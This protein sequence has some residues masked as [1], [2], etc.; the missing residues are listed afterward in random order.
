MHAD[1]SAAVLFFNIRNLETL[2]IW[3]NGS[4]SD[5]R[6]EGW[7]FV[8]LCG[9]LFKIEPDDMHDKQFVDLEQEVLNLIV[10]TGAMAQR[11]RV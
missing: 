2:A 6:S 10:I 9:H 3:R 4:A 8:S 5:S 11:Q 7:E 1:L